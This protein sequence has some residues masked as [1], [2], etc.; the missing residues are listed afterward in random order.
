MNTSDYSDVTNSILEDQAISSLMSR[1]REARLHTLMNFEKP[2]VDADAA[3]M[4]RLTQLMIASALQ[5][6]YESQQAKD[7]FAIAYDLLT[8]LPID[9]ERGQ[10]YFDEIMGLEGI[11]APTCFYFYL[12]VTGL[13]SRNTIQVRLRLREY[14]AESGESESIS[15]QHRVLSSCMSATI[16]LVRKFKWNL[17]YRAGFTIH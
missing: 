13:L 15:W 2:E 12:S 17:R 11:P 16:H 6:P 7:L 1:G 8:A 10:L 3:K 5:K 14:R 9:D 4:T